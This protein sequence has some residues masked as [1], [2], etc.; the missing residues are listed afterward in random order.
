MKTEKESWEERNNQLGYEVGPNSRQKN[1]SRQRY[2][3]GDEQNL[4]GDERQN[5][6]KD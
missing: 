4:M 1:S 5:K 3:N 6:N 2:M